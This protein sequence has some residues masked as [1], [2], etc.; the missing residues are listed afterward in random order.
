VRNIDRIGIKIPHFLCV[1]PQRTG[2]TW[3]HSIL[4][5]NGLQLPLGVKETRFFDL[6]FEK[7]RHW[8]FSHFGKVEK[9]KIYGEVAPTYF[10]DESVPPRVYSFNPKCKIIIILRDPIT[11]TLSL[12]QHLCARGHLVGNFSEAIF[13]YPRL[14]SS[15][16]YSLHVPRWKLYFKERVLLILYDDIISD[17][18]ATLERIFDFLEIKH[19]KIPDNVKE[20]VNVAKIPRNLHLAKIFVFLSNKFHKHKYHNFVALAK[21]LGFERLIFKRCKRYPSYITKQ[22]GRKLLELFEKEIRY[23][24]ELLHRRLPS[25]RRPLSSSRK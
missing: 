24:E 11:R 7:G 12:Y 17:P 3:L 23:V 2:T 1:G 21:R 20:K 13:K 25:W 4:K 18:A 15:S 19:F 16:Y 9:N 10:D 5:A 14:L 22:E 6:Y 8:Y